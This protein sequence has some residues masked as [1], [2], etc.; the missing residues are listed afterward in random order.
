MCGRYSLIQ[1]AHEDIMQRFRAT[2]FAGVFLPR[3]NIAPGQN[4]LTVL[5]EYPDTIQ[6]AKWG[7]V[8][9]WA[10]DPVV[11]NR[12]IN[13]RAETI[14]EKPAFRGSIRHKRCL[15]PAD[16][17]YEW[18]RDTPTKKVPYRITLKDDS[19]FSFA[20][21]WDI[22]EKDGKHVLLTASIITTSANS[23]VGKI[24]ERMPVILKKEDEEKWLSEKD[25]S[26]AVKLLKPY[27]PD[28]MM[29]YEISSLINAPL[30]DDPSV[31]RPVITE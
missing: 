15:I 9:S 30:N 27:D 17:F 18:K 7:L 10:K 13:A 14:T 12:M 8:P 16:G 25:L 29:A 3:Y 4:I 1:G 31:I 6:T 2:K 21:I 19:I 5:N 23:V 28:M 26:S 11:G 20:G 22:W 24:H